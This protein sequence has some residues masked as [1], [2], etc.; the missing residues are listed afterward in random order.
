MATDGAIPGVSKILGVSVGGDRIRMALAS[1]PAGDLGSSDQRARTRQDPPREL[2][3]DELLERVPAQGTP[4]EQAV[5]LLAALLTDDSPQ[6]VPVRSVVI[7]YQDAGQA[8]RFEHALEVQNVSGCALVPAAVATLAQLLVDRGVGVARAIAVVTLDP[9][10]YGCGL[11]SIS[12]EAIGEARRVPTE[13]LVAADL[14]VHSAIAT[15]LASTARAS[16]QD[17]DLVV[18]VGEN[19]LDVGDPELLERALG[20][21]VI[22]PDAPETILARGA[23]LLPG[24]A[25][26]VRPGAAATPGLRELSR[27]PHARPDWLPSVGALLGLIGLLALGAGAVVLLAFSGVLPESGD[28]DG[29]P[30]TTVT[31]VPT[32]IEETDED[33]PPLIPEPDP[34]SESPAPPPPPPPPPAP[35]PEPEPE[36]APEPAPEPPPEPA[37]PVIDIPGV[38]EIEIPF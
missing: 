8:K 12:G 10:Q 2:D 31:T 27:D 36:P 32:P 7:A 38:G 33:A 22:V 14:D 13:T 35:E 15:V 24:R 21:P 9:W 23:S 30:A 29:G 6:A 17:P 5:A 11:V 37:P 28:S 25:S 34:I 19:A 3:V 16:G 18:V 20:L 1:A 26:R 4:E